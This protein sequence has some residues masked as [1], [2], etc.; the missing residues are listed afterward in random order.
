MRRY[1]LP[2]LL[3]V[4]ILFLAGC[5][6]TKELPKSDFKIFIEQSDSAWSVTATM[7]MSQVTIPIYPQPIFF[8][9]DI[10][11]VS[12][13]SSNLGPCLSFYLTRRAAITFYRFSVES[14]GRKLVLIKDGEPIGLS[15]PIQDTDFQGAFLIFPEIDPAILPH[16]T[17]ELNQIIAQ[18]NRLKRH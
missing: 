10:D 15:L 17:D 12:V 14:L 5:Q 1:F 11:H 7:P 3:W 2:K 18:L 9:T 6:S 4:S 8:A 16:L 13:E